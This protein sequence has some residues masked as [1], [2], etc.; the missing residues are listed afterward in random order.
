MTIPDRSKTGRKS[1]LFYE[2]W[3]LMA[4]SRDTR[5]KR[6]AFYDAIMRFA[7][8][9]EVPQTPERGVSAGEAW[10]AHDGYL[11]CKPILDGTV[12]RE[13]KMEIYRK[14]GQNGKGVTRN[15]GN[16]NAR[17]SPDEKNNSENNSENNTS[18]SEKTIVKTILDSEKNNTGNNTDSASLY[19]IKEKENIN[20]NTK[21]KEKEKADRRLR[22]GSLSDD[23][24]TMFDAWWKAYPGIRKQDKRKCADK[25]ARI[26]RK[27]GDAVSMFNRIMGGLDK[28]R[29]CETWTHDGGR[30][31]CAPL[32]WL[33]NERWD[34][35]I[36]IGPLS[37][38]ID[39]IHREQEQ[40]EV[41]NA[42]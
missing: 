21:E 19:N 5:P 25:F 20:P 17:K 6:L 27:S 2:N 14:G 11:V 38:G 15:Q 39:N 31:I 12:E 9:G 8:L 26:L 40:T 37:G 32:V 16:A 23:E 4:E 22:D 35:E 7:F 28:W 18:P 36:K 24:E 13:E 3:W 33:N 1:V 41:S 10:A 42:F 30:Y 34:A 29:R